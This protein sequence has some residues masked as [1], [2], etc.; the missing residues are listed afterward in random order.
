L[1]AGV[2]EKATL[3]TFANITETLIL[4]YFFG[5]YS[6]HTRLSR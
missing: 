3:Y 5:V 4:L 6:H 2:E 1:L